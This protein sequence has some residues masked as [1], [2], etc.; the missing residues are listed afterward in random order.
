MSACLPEVQGKTLATPL[1]LCLLVIELA[2]RCPPPTFVR[3]LVARFSD[4]V[5]ATDS[6]PAVLGTTQDTESLLR[7]AGAMQTAGYFLFFTLLHRT[8]SFLG[9]VLK[10]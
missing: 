1:F 5:F 2:P 8:I 7:H 10:R 4:I 9:R 6:V 3:C